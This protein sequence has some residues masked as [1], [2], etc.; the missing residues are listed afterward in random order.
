LGTKV[1]ITGSNLL[2]VSVVFFNGTPTT[3]F[4]VT[5]DAQLDDVVVPGGA[6]TGPLTVVGPGGSATS[7]NF[8]Y[9]PP[10]LTRLTPTNGI[11]GSSV[12]LTG[13]NFT[14]VS[15]VEFTAGGGTFLGT[16]FTTTAARIVAVVPT[17]A[18]TGP[19]RVTAPGGVITSTNSFLVQPKIY[20][21][22]PLT[23]PAGTLVTISG[24]GF[25]TVTNVRFNGVNAVFTNLS[26]TEVLAVVPAGAATGPVSLSTAADTTN[27]AVAFTVVPAAD[28]SLRFTV[29]PVVGQVN[30]P[31]TCT[32]VASNAG[33]LP[34]T[35]VRI[36]NDVPA[37]AQFV[38]F[39]NTA[40]LAT[41]TDS[42]IIWT[43]P[44]L[45]EGTGA[46]LTV[47]V[48]ATNTDTLTYQAGGAAAEL[49]ANI[50]DNTAFLSVPVVTAAQRTLSI[51]RA[52]NETGVELAWPVSSALFQLQQAPG[53][54]SGG[55][56]AWLNVG[57]VG[58]LTNSNGVFHVFST[59][60]AGEPQLFRLKYP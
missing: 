45:A 34:A 22:A 43:F 53:L 50:A 59:N 60:P 39:T 1:Q 6:T 24:N 46:R 17:N 9:L 26:T 51:Q 54:P 47:I 38:S 32:L 7:T 27:S 25:N 18:L 20:S 5:S 19:L 58:R 36:T 23:G 48:T 11:V 2:G 12:T 30:Q 28:L 41:R 8:F 56:A 35:S 37:N 44:V 42:T 55:P 4:L 57:G 33:S 13:A 52:T 14:G 15:A 10:R 16:S 40:G 31:L 29:V 3:T 21:L 49:E